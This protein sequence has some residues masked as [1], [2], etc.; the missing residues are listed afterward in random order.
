MDKP[1]PSDEKIVTAAPQ[2]QPSTPDDPSRPGRDCEATCAVHTAP[3]GPTQRRDR[4]ASPELRRALVILLGFAVLS[5]LVVGVVFAVDF[6]QH[7]ADRD[8][9]SSWWQQYVPPRRW[10][11]KPWWERRRGEG[12]RDKVVG[13]LVVVE[14]AMGLGSEGEG[15]IRNERRWDRPYFA[16]AG[17]A[18]GCASLGQPVSSSLSLSL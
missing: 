10:G 14:G 12:R 2:S 6:A 9:N 1:A 5:I 16:C 7:R 18:V 11:V 3:A 15:R 8:A 17:T 13:A 4:C